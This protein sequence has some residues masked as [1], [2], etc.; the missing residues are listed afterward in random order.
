MPPSSILRYEISFLISFLN[1]SGIAKHAEI[2][3]SSKHKSFTYIC[4]YFIFSD[5]VASLE[6]GPVCTPNINGI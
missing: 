2:G 6:F 5:Y 1:S 3:L 4:D